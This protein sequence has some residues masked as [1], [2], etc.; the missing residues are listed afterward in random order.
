MPEKVQNKISVLAHAELMTLLPPREQESHKGDFGHV[1]LVGGHR[2]FCGAIRLAGEAALRVGSGLVSIATKKEHAA[3]LTLSRPELMCHG[4]ADQR[5]LRR[6]ATACDVIGIGPGLG[7]T[8][9]SSSLY[10]A[11]LE[12]GLAAVVDADGLNLL[13]RSPRKNNNW[14]LTPHVGEAARL[15]RCSAADIQL[16]RQAAVKELQNEYGGVVVLK[17]SG[18]LVYGGGDDIYMC[19]AGNPGMASGG[20]GDVLTGV[21]SGLMAQGLTILDAAKMA[22]M[23]HAMAAD[24]AAQKGQRGLLASDLMQPIR[25]LVNDY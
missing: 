3:S 13:S 21:I 17:G 20:M 14:V 6:I 5:E 25:E 7:Q 15:L 2:G 9:W 23:V 1:L 11:A 4:V 22:V 19:K 18:S 24:C 10:E 12:T 16:D 8:R